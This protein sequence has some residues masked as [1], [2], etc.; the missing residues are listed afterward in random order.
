MSN[1]TGGQSSGNRKL[2]GGA[3][4]RVLVVDDEDQLLDAYSRWLA[5]AGF[6]VETATSGTAAAALL[7]KAEYDVVVSDISMPGLDGVS[8]L[9]LARGRDADLPVVLV[10]GSPELQ[11]AIEAL[12]SGAFDYLVKPFD[13]EKLSHVVERANLLHRMARLKREA[14]NL[15]GGGGMGLADRTAL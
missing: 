7:E 8:L 4:G 5:R 10:T 15:V 11:S 2:Q 13:L 1:A 12:R 6:E 14:L 3:R 9:R